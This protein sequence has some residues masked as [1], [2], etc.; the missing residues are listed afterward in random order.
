MPPPVEV[1][2]PSLAPLQKGTAILAM[3]NWDDN[4]LKTAYVLEKVHP[5]NPHVNK[6]VVTFG[7]PLSLELY[8]NEAFVPTGDV[9]PTDKWKLQ[10]M[11]QRVRARQLEKAVRAA[12]NP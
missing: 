7:G 10:T 11:P 2:V 1:P 3:D 5:N 9:L 8:V 12:A 4:K 6:Y